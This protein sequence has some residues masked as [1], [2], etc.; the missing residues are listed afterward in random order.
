MACIS[1]LKLA[2]LPLEPGLLVLK[3]QKGHAVLEEAEAILLQH[4]GVV[5]DKV[6]EQGVVSLLVSEGHQQGT[7]HLNMHKIHALPHS[8]G[9]GGHNLECVLLA[10]VGI[11]V[12]CLLQQVTQN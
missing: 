5:S 11:R 3:A 12:R 4:R 2:Q 7:D 1:L 10:G 6:I 8:K 9:G